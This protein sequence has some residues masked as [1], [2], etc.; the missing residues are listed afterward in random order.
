[1]E[2]SELGSGFRLALRDLEI[3]G[4]GELLGIRQHGYAN[5]VGLSLYCDLVAAEVKKLKGQYVP[6]PAPAAV[7]L[8]LPA[9]IPPDYMPSDSE[10]LRYYKEFMA[11]DAAQKRLLLKTLENIAG[12]APAEVLNLIETMQLSQDAGALHIRQIEGCGDFT[13]FYFTK[14]FKIPPAAVGAMLERFKSNIKFLQAPNGDGIRVNH[15]AGAL[16]AGGPAQTAQNLL[17]AL[18]AVLKPAA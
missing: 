18:A 12:P 9:Y 1:M 16:Y 8:R 17:G 11:A 13:E 2:F 5:E 15:G 14:D 10:R 7:N 6:R 3:R 4:G